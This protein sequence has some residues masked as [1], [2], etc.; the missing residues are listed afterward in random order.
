MRYSSLRQIHARNVGGLKLAWTFRTDKPGS[1]AIPI[2]VDGV[3]YVTA[4]DGVYALVPETGELL[5][6]YDASPVAL[7]GLAYWPGAGAVHP[8]VFT[9]NGSYL[10]ALDT[11]T[12]KP[13]PAF[14]DEGRLD[15]LKGV[16]GDLKNGRY[17]L[18]S[19]PA[20]FGD[21]VITGCSNG[22]GRPSAG[23][24]GDIRGWDA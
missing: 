23:A 10:L 20:V 4:P 21:I 12:G 24:Y 16:L 14:G 11:V 2:V 18:Q 9:G 7:R 5:W 13:A 19:P 15:L 22:E 3:M 1:E 6:K 8:R 17:D